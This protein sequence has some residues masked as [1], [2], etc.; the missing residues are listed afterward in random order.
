MATKITRWCLNT[1]TGNI[2]PWNDSM[3]FVDDLV[4]CNKNGIP[5]SAIEIVKNV[6]INTIEFERASKNVKTIK[7]DNDSRINND[8]DDADDV[9]DD[10]VD[11]YDSIPTA[12]SYTDTVTTENT[13]VDKEESLM[14]LLKKSL[15][16]MAQVKGIIND[17]ANTFNLT[18]R[19][20]VHMIM[21]RDEENGE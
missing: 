10:T 6:D 4:E 3:R 12:N 17:D 9:I 11:T 20:L 14:K 21:Q 2:K 13:F 7:T 19:E 18:K 8:N 5:L 15:V 16:E 1:K